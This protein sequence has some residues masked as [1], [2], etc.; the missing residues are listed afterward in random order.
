MT[1]KDREFLND[2]LNKLKKLFAE[3][4]DGTAK[5]CPEFW[6]KRFENLKKMKTIINRGLK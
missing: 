6:D 4:K 2:E 3:M 1:D 5:P